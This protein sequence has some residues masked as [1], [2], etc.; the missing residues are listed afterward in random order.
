[1]TILCYHA[2]D[3]TWQ[4]TLVVAPDE[5]ARHC[6]WLATNRTV[7]PLARAAEAF[8]KHRR[9]PFGWTAI[10]FDDGFEGLY[11]HALPVLE[12][13]R[14]P[15]T[16]FLVAQT[17]TDEGRVVDWV[18]DAPPTPPTTLDLTQ[19]RDMKERGVNFGSHSF[20]HHDLTSLTESA[21]AEDLKQSRALLEDLL[22]DR[23]PHLA[24]PRGRHNDIVRR[25]AARAGY[26]YAFSL[27]EKREPVGRH[28]VPRAGIYPDDGV[29]SLR[30]KSSSRYLS[31]RMNPVY[32]WARAIARKT[33]ATASR[34]SHKK[35]VA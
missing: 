31:L 21:C 2:V 25:A 17:L 32:P 18:D 34:S 30:A 14:L 5:F 13:H 19:V 6:E 4:S 11:E 22:E 15:S 12:R 23:V 24:Y 33:R 20:S 10:T 9:L 35:N 29:G 28:A 1:M 7:V 26:E 16:V 27:P 8:E 3:D